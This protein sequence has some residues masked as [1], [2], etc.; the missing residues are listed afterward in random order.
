MSKKRR[1]R[2]LPKRIAGVKVPK[3]VRRYAET[4]LGAALI[5]ETFVLLGRE[6]LAS[7][8][9]RRATAEVRDNLART[10]QVIAQGLRDISQRNGAHENA[11]QESSPEDRRDMGYSAERHAE[12]GPAY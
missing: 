4:P 3:S 6:A 10:G 12:T 2:S 1:I 8:G 9:V 5:A 7:P 11:E